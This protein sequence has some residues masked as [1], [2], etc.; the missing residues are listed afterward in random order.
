MRK[1]NPDN[2]YI[3]SQFGRYCIMTCILSVLSQRV[4]RMNSLRSGNKVLGDTKG[5]V[6]VTVHS[7]ADS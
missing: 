1:K 2:H 3:Q 5:E 4:T 6:T 7:T